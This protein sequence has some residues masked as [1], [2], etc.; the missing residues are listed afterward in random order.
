MD[1][2]ATFTNPWVLGGGVVL[3]LLLIARSGGG[4]N[5]AS[6]DAP[7]I[8]SAFTANN[9]IAAQNYASSTAARVALGQKAYEANATR[10]GFFAS[11]LTNLA[12]YQGQLQLGLAQSAQ[13]AI[14]YSLDRNTALA[15]N[16]SQNVGREREAAVT[17][18]A[19][20]TSSAIQS[21]KSQQAARD[22][23]NASM[24]SSIANSGFT[25]FS[26]TARAAM[27]A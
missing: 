26:D 18:G 3:G 15:I 12:Q 16:I 10:A 13:G 4:G 7:A 22:A 5:S 19:N 17:A 25:A 2:K 24:W 8:M 6:S 14:S 1:L 23:A 21:I 9:Q 20:V 11:T 27:R